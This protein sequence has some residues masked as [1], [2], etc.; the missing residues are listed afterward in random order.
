ML[1]VDRVRGEQCQCRE[2]PRRGA[3][4]GREAGGGIDSLCNPRPPPL[5]WRATPPPHLP[6]SSRPFQVLAPLPQTIIFNPPGA[7][8]KR[9]SGLCRRI[10]SLK[11]ITDPR[12]SPYR[13][14]T[15]PHAS[16]PRSG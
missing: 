6:I 11:S 10:A 12:L 14:P 7:L 16:T 4:L 13:P 5:Q 1:V 3:G 15:P 8:L 9:I 2:E